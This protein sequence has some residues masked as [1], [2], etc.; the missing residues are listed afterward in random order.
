LLNQKR[1]RRNLVREMLALAAV[2][3]ALGIGRHLPAAKAQGVTT[4]DGRYYDAYVPA[5]SKEG[6]FY[7]YTCEFDA[8]WVVLATFG[9]EVGFE[10][11]LSIVGHDTSIEPYYE[12]TPEGFFIYG[13][14]I[15]QAFSGDYYENM[16]ARCTG[17]AMMPIFEKYQLDATP[18]N[19][20][21]GIEQTLD[22]GGLVW[23]KATADF[24]PWAATTW[25]TPSG[26]Q[27]PT[28]LG[29]DHAVVVMGYND[30]GP[31]IRDVLGPTSSNWGR[32]YEYDI[33]WEQ[34]LGVFGAQ[35]FD[36]IGVLPPGTVAA[37]NAGRTI[38][39]AP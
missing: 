23:M 28:V 2:P 8:A 30:F 15:T 38:Q 16:L 32:L 24:L 18:V 7:H 35:D 26:Q 29:N 22:K 11:Q 20:R 10:E 12:E 3:P 6:Q 33:P 21:A 17:Q 14:E 13:G 27:L 19:D 36:G 37:T 1:T 39:P 31:V 25:I 34:F 5:A 9:N 4:P